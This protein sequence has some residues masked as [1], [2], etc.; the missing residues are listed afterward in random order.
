MTYSILGHSIQVLH[1]QITR[2]ICPILPL[3]VYETSIAELCPNYLK[4]NKPQGS[5]M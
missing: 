3:I 5:Y 2:N 4:D 1:E